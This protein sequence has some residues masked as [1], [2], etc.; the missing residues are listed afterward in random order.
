M[1]ITFRSYRTP[2]DYHLVDRFF[3]EH[4]RP[5]NADGNWLQPAWEYMHSHS[6]L[7]RLSLGKIGLWEDNGQL[8]A[9]VHYESSLGEAFFQ[10]HPAYR[11]LREE[12][13][14]Y[15]EKNLFGC[16]EQGRAF[17]HAY[18]NDNDPEFQ[19]LLQSR[20]YHKDERATRPLYQ[21]PVP[22]PFPTIALP[23]GYRLASMADNCDWEKI[24]RV[25]W[26]GFDH[27]GEPPAE[28]LSDRM[29][30][31]NTPNFNHNIQIVT[32]A[33]NGDFASFCGMWYQPDHQYTYVE[34]VA[35]DPTYRRL[36]LGKAAV[37]EGIRR[38]AELG[39]RVAFVGSDQAFYQAIG[40]VKVHNSECWGKKFGVTTQREL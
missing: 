32:V 5:A 29:T 17:L 30:M 28:Y 35:T 10:F 3:I 15:A 20:G 16:D 31:Q 19:A 21:V 18:A 14:D 9:V 22:D 37:Q 33:P 40:F 12:M 24:H 7:D 39:A 8:A 4:F 23:D 26:R 2:F 11:E 13:L 34:P 6:M 36:G 1:P 25:L 38:C 27:P